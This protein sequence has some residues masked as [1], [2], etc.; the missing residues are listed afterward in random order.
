[1][2]SD[3]CVCVG[4][5]MSHPYFRKNIVWLK[6]LLEVEDAMERE[7]WDGQ[8][9]DDEGHPKETAAKYARKHLT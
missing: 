3:I 4:K 8:T 1:L 9:H 5:D 2:C 6:Q 7:D